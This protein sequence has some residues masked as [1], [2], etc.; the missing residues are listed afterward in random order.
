MTQLFRRK[1]ETLEGY[2]PAFTREETLLGFKYEKVQV[3]GG[4]GDLDYDPENPQ[5]VDRFSIN[6]L[7]TVIEGQGSYGYKDNFEITAL[8]ANEFLAKEDNRVRFPEAYAYLIANAKNL[9]DSKRYWK[10]WEH[11]EKIRLE[12][13]KL[14][15]MSR[16]IARAEIIASVNA[17]MVKAQRS[18]STEER[19]LLLAEFSGGE[20]N[21]KEWE[22][23]SAACY[24]L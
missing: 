2:Q 22:D 1:P 4:L 15:R 14:A 13:D 18:F 17:V 16:R 19:Q 6:V 10:S 24:D 12:K 3:G 20:Y 23:E 5:F 9:N 8:I 7:G 11:L 21:A